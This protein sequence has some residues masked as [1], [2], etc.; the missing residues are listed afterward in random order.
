MISM[1]TAPR[2]DIRS[3]ASRAAWSGPAARGSVSPTSPY[4]PR[5]I[6][7]P[8]HTRSREPPPVAGAASQRP[9]RLWL[10]G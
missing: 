2:L 6:L 10:A 7:T 1:A 5:E 3:R 9:E 8:E 4:L